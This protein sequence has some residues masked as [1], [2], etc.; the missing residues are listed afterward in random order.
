M[1]QYSVL[2]SQLLERVRSLQEASRFLIPSKRDLRWFGK[3]RYRAQ[4]R[5]LAKGALDAQHHGS[6]LIGYFEGYEARGLFQESCLEE[7]DAED[8]W[9]CCALLEDVMERLHKVIVRCGE[10]GYELHPSGPKKPGP[11]RTLEAAIHHLQGL[12]KK[13]CL[14]LLGVISAKEKR[15]AVEERRKR[16]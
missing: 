16:L 14:I 8:P 10:G 11:Q 12:E 3:G 13:L 2:F 9:A 6:A 15:N 5:M 7:S 1:K 4:W